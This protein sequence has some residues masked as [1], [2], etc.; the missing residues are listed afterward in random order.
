[1][2]NARATGPRPVGA[3]ITTLHTSLVKCNIG[4]KRVDVAGTSAPTGT[5]A[6][7]KLN[8]MEA[9]KRKAK[10][11]ADAKKAAMRTRSEV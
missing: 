1:M 8:K 2:G 7:I 5:R 4:H 11:A 6:E 9:L 3:Y 10:Q